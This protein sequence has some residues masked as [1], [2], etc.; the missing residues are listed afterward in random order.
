M[1]KLNI[2]KLNQFYM[3]GGNSVEMKTLVEKCVE[4]FVHGETKNPS[5]ILVLSDLGLL[6]N[7]E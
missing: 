4:N 7:A 5:A 3:N 1:K 2:K 6:M